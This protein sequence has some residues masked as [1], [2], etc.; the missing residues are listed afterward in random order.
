MLTALSMEGLMTRR[1]VLC[2]AFCSLTACG[3]EGSTHTG[4][5]SEALVAPGALPGRGVT[6]LVVTPVDDPL[7][8][9]S[10]AEQKTSVVIRS[11]AGYRAAFGHAPPAS[12][13]FSAGDVVIFYS[14][15][16]KPTGGYA[17][18]IVSVVQIG[19]A[20]SVATLLT[21]P[22][23]GC[24][25]TDALTTPYALVK[26]TPRGRTYSAR[27]Q[28]L[29]SVDDCEPPAGC[30]SIECPDGQHCELQEIV[31]ITTPCDPIPECVDD[32][33]TS[34]FCGGF[35]GFP[36]PGS[37]E[38]VDDPSDDCDPEMGGADCGGICTCEVLGLCVT[39]FEW[40]SSPEV[41][42]CTPIENPCNLI[43][44]MPGNTCV[45]RDGEA[46]CI[47]TTG[48]GTNPCAFTL[49]PV[50][51]DCVERDGEAVCIPTTGG[52]EQ[53]GDVTCGAGQV[54]C[55]ASCGICTPPDSAC[56]QIACL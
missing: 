49:C 17:A 43:D 31:C 15:G 16:V 45:V 27:F 4:S 7:G 47:P 41:C 23:E 22:G 51:T 5:E 6:P 36:C 50:N 39:G 11:A 26:V 3:S 35:A 33:P 30:D 25:T 42:D 2:L 40:N 29:H 8:V 44:C 52:G 38:C 1:L 20:L 55:N 18:S 28:H 34:T 54:C 48:G 19:R 10:A 53:C 37:G 13:D 12:V 9:G 14:D 56:I 21:S 32:T 24:I 46:V